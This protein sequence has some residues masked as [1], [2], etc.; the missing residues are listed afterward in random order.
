MMT[1]SSEALHVEHVARKRHRCEA[2]CCHVAPPGWILPGDR[3]VLSSLPP[4]SDVDNP[5]WWHARFHV[6][7]IEPG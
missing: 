7:C 4:N 3:Y 5:T 2:T 6:E 1:R